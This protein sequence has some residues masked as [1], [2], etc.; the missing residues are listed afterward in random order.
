M[1]GLGRISFPTSGPPAAK[2]HFN[3]GKTY[4]FKLADVGGPLNAGAPTPFDRTKI[5]S[6]HFHVVSNE[7]STVPFSY[8]ISN[9]RALKD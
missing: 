6:M 7:T 4:S 3:T 2:L 1:I 5:L 8:C 9:L